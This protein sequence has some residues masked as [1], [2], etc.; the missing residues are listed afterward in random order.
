MQST[1]Q[2]VALN[3][4]CRASCSVSAAA[5]VTML[6]SQVAVATGAETYATHA[7]YEAIRLAQ[8]D[9]AK[10][11]DFRIASQPMSEAL[12][13][14]GAQSGLTIIVE[15]KVSRGIKAVALSGQYTPEQALKILLE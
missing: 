14:F 9:T 1:R 12:T 3:S 15:T 5:A 11:V 2:A 6:L 4:L 7:K 8:N 13:A 10:V